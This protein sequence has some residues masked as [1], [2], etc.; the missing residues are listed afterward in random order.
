MSLRLFLDSPMW[1][2]PFSLVM[3]GAFALKPQI[4]HNI[5]LQAPTS[6][7]SACAIM[8]PTV[9][10]AC[11]VPSMHV[12]YTGRAGWIGA[13]DGDQMGEKRSKK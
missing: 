11:M 5:G 6:S 12:Q 7:Q 4:G 9:Y 8:R 1:T 3:S 10:Q 2:L 13:D